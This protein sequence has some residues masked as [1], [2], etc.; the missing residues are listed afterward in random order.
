MEESILNWLEVGDSVQKLDVYN[1]KFKTTAFKIFYNISKHMYFSPFL[2]YFLI[3]VFFLQIFVLNISGTNIEKDKLLDIFKYLE[4]VLLFEKSIDNEKQYKII[5]IITIIFFLTTFIYEIIIFS[6]LI[7]GITLNYFIKLLSFYQLLYIY[8]L[9]GPMVQILIYPLVASK[10]SFTSDNFSLLI[11]YILCLIIAVIIII[12]VILISFYMTDINNING[13]DYKS[14]INDRYMTIIINIKVIY[15]IIEQILALIFPEN[16]YFIYAFQI[17]L[18]VINLSVSVYV[19]KKVYFYN[20]VINT[21][22]HLGWYFTSWFSV[23]IFFKHLTNTKDITL[24]FFVGIILIG[25]SLYFSSNYKVFKLLTEF[26]ILSENK[27]KDI[28]IYSNILFKLSKQNDPKSKTLLAGIIK[29]SEESIKSNPELNDIYNRLTSKGL[30][31]EIF[32]TYNEVKVLSLIGMVY[33]NNEEKSKNRAEVTLNRSYFLINKC[34]N[35]SL[36]AHL[37]TKVNI[38]SHLQAYYKYVLLEEIK[39]YLINKL[40][41]TRNKLT[42]K[43]VQI[44]T[45][46]L[47]SQ[48]VDLFKIEIYDAVCSQIEYFD[49]LRNNVA[50]EKVTENFLKTGENI[51]SLRKNIVTIWNKMIELN[52]NDPEAEKDYMIYL[53]IIIQDEFLKKEEIKKYKEK[54]DEFYREKNNIY[55]E[56]FDQEKSAIL[57]CDGYSFNGKIFYYTPNFASLFGF[58]G[59][60]ISNISIDDLLPD[61]VQ[62]FHKYLLEEYLKYTNLMAI[63]KTKKNLLLKGK[64]G[65]LF[66]VYLYVRILP[67]LQYGLLYILYI[68]KNQE[69]NFMIILD[70]KMHIDGFTESGQINSN[71]TINNV[72]NYGLSQFV[73]GYHIGLIIPDILLQID[74]DEKNEK[75]FF[76]KENIDLKGYFY[77]THTGKEMNI[78]I[79]KILDIIK[80]KKINENEEENNEEKFNS[81]DEFNEFIKEIKSQNKRAYSIFYRI[82]CRSFLDGKYRYYKIY[83][84]NDLLSDNFNDVISN[85]KNNLISNTDNNLKDSKSLQDNPDKN[86]ERLIKLKINPVNMEIK[87]KNVNN[88]EVKTNN[89]NSKEMNINQNKINFSQPTSNSSSILS[90]TNKESNEFHKLKNEIINKK[91]FFYI[92]LIKYI[93]VFYLLIIVALIVYDYLITKKYINALAEFLTENLYFDHTRIAAANVYNTAFNFKLLRNKIIK[94]EDCPNSNCTSFYSDLL[95]KSYTEIRKLKYDLNNFFIDY[96]EIFNKKMIIESKSF[97][98]PVSEYLH[99]DVDNYMN[100]LIANGLKITANIT[101]YFANG[102]EG[103]FFGFS[104]YEVLDVYIDNILNASYNVYYSDIFKGF[105]GKDKETRCKKHSDNPPKRLII[106]CAVFIIVVIIIINLIYKLYST[107]CFFLEKLIN[108][109]SVNFD[110]YL[111]KLEELKKSLRD[112]NNEDE[113]KNMDENDNEEGLEEKNEN[114]NL[115][116]NNLKMGLI[117]KKENAKKKKNKQNKLHLQKLKKKKNMTNYFFKFNIF[118]AVKISI[119]FFIVVIY[120]MVTMVI[121][122]NYR[123]NFSEFD[124]SLV[125]INEIFLNIFQTFTHFKKQIEKFYNTNNTNDII[126]PKDSDI[127][128]PKLGNTLFNIIHNS[129]YNKDY[130]NIIKALY[131]E[132]ACEILNQNITND[133][134]CGVLFSSL[135]VKGLDQVIVQLSIIL[136]NCLDELSTLKIDKN[137]TNMYSIDNFYYNYEMLVGYYIY[138]SFFI[139]RDAFDVFK[140]DE[141]KHI[142]NIQKAITAVYSI[143]VV[144]VLFLCIYF[145]YKYKNIVSSFWNF[146][147]ILPNKFISDDENF[148]DSI[149]KLGEL[150]F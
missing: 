62:S 130:L 13:M 122:E 114:E 58:T 84:T 51:L 78:K 9:T 150:L 24:F 131:N 82:E 98:I 35:L 96:L 103:K 45:V 95:I 12:N 132:N 49:V 81:F 137:L 147:G 123:V 74:Y 93:F 31:V 42:M 102:S 99:L 20:E 128:Q 60:E 44:S 10:G 133:K 52:P 119:A 101:N 38:T 90:K 7:A 105:I 126:I 97:K 100:Y 61:V 120:F 3:I 68:Q 26:N 136:N 43:N 148:Y 109:S 57:L 21:L 50:T 145:I 76:M 4:K 110:E 1:N 125:S 48:L 14:K 108:F 22:H 124:K 144:F 113:D 69:K 46:I 55:F 15:F 63:F 36:A 47:Y 129:K 41:K 18:L 37:A 39:A 79:K 142:T 25:F 85:T 59:K 138:N 146:I 64:N 121:F 115:E 34:K 89:N 87:K 134:Y 53:N 67:N 11:A 23:C 139:T 16:K 27:I 77:P 28:E 118:F 29:K 140:N 71:L 143:V 117:K 92:K 80:A 141:I 135:L 2:H 83:I 149:I 72:S 86:K 91:D 5:I 111:K 94:E 30:N 19:Y 106:A 104:S 33:I 66:N 116:K 54:K 8:Y 6:L 88:N 56:M 107:E 65:L 70:D 127:V 73:I 112:E 40:K 32:G 17:F 75:Y